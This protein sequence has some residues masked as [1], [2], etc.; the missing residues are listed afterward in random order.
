MVPASLDIE[1]HEVEAKSPRGHQ[2]L[3]LCGG[4]AGQRRWQRTQTLDQGQLR[5]QGQSEK[6]SSN[7]T[8]LCR[9][10]GL[11]NESRRLELPTFFLGHPTLEDLNF[12]G[13]WLWPNL[14]AAVENELLIVASKVES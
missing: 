4:R 14:N 2:P 9:M 8:G 13:T 1:S 5:V 3:T 12:S 7:W 11:K 6:C 10:D